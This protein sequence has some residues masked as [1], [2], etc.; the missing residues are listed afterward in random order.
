MKE[1]F[2]HY[3]WRYS[4]FDTQSLTTVDGKELAIV[5]PGQYLQ[6]AGP[7]FFNAQV[8]LDKQKWAGNVEI[9]LKSSDWYAHRHETDSAYGSVILHVVWEHDMP[10]F[11]SDQTEI[12]TLELKGRVP[13]ATL[14]R[15]HNLLSSREWIYCERDI[16]NVDAFHF[17]AW[18][19]R[20]F[21][22]RLERKVSQ[23]REWPEYRSG[24]W[25][26]VLFRMLA[27]NFG[28]NYNGDVFFRMSGLLPFPVI[29]KEAG[30]PMRL[31]AL[32]MGLC[33]MLSGEKE[34]AYGQSLQTEFVYLSAKYGLPP[35]V[36]EAVHF[37]KLRPDN[38]PTIRLS[39]LASLYN[40]SSHLFTSTMLA[41]SA[42]AL[43]AILSSSTSAYWESH[44]LFDRASRK[45]S[46]ET[47]S[48]FL[49]LLIINTI[50][51]LRFL[52]GQSKGDLPDEDLIP[53]LR[54]IK[55]EQNA[56][57]ERFAQIG[58]PAADA[59]ETQALLELKTS[60]CARARCL[61]CTVGHQLLRTE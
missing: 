6:V 58:V 15:Y 55:P 48:S 19:E 10:V 38:F 59:F 25:E 4:K 20:L 21:F 39:Q 23:V 14:A 52:Y 42:K 44:Y 27:R 8:V 47:S 7:D 57:V 30:D 5:H 61:E 36:P 11:R 16:A 26:A 29:R 33:G 60:F 56:V 31:E 12:P 17:S 34:D 18:L 3:V 49:D 54:Q 46:K 41:D 43:R 35:P 51:P 53:L 40:R 28:L 32:F 45:R 22:E 13:A 1:D 9:H 50:V 24:D 2:L 37:F